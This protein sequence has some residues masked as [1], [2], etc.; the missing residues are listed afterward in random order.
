MDLTGFC[1]ALILE[2]SKPI[3]GTL[4]VALD[5]ASYL[6]AP[7]DLTPASFS[8]SLGDI[9]RVAATMQDAAIA[10]LVEVY[11][12]TYHSAGVGESVRSN[13]RQ[14]SAVAALGY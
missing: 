9:V 13:A 1:V 7:N 11:R 14:I 2:L 6:D 5:V 4:P 3:T 12:R 10:L 8:A